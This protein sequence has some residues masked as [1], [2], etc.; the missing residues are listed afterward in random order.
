MITPFCKTYLKAQGVY[1]DPEIA[2]P[3]CHA[4]RERQAEFVPVV[5]QYERGDL[6]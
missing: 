4:I 5:L 3:E 2:K 6:P 1:I